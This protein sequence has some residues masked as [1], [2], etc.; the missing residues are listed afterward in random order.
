[1]IHVLNYFNNS[2]TIIL[3]PSPSLNPQKNKVLVFKNCIKVLP[4]NQ[5]GGNVNLVFR[6]AVRVVVEPEQKRVAAL[7]LEQQQR[8][9]RFKRRSFEFLVKLGDA[10]AATE[11]GDKRIAFGKMRSW[12]GKVDVVA[13]VVVERQ[14]RR[15]L[16]NAAGKNR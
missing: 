12:M 16:G 14:V 13:D 6:G 7:A 15:N 5:V 8:V 2:F 4:I 11:V 3:L 1:M 10:R 9:D